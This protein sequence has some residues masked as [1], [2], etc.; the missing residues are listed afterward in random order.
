M[1]PPQLC[2]ITR[3]RPCPPV[4]V[5][6]EL[7]AQERLAARRQAHHDDC[8]PPIVHR[9]P[10]GDVRC[11]RERRERSAGRGALR[12]A[13][14]VL[15]PCTQNLLNP[16]RWWGDRAHTPIRRTAKRQQKRSI[17]RRCSP[18]PPA[19]DLDSRPTL[20]YARALLL[21]P[22][23]PRAPSMLLLPEGPE[24]N[25]AEGFDRRRPS[26][27]SA[28]KSPPSVDT[29]RRSLKLI[30]LRTSSCGRLRARARRW[31]QGVWRGGG[32]P[33]RLQWGRR[34]R[35]REAPAA[36]AAG[37][38]ST[39]EIWSSISGRQSRATAAA[40]RRR[41]RAR[42]QPKRR[43][44]P[45]AAAHAAR[46]CCCTRAPGP[47]SRLPR[48]TDRIAQ[49]TIDG[50]ARAVYNPQIEDSARRQPKSQRRSPL[51]RRWRLRASY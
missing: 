50:V 20:R 8:Q 47:R 14:Q 12:S 46:A 45:S 38:A 39:A 13:A 41:P 6:H 2:D 25:P 49:C 17:W 5:R 7:V 28:S 35:L 9:H 31:M 29:S 10:R 11:E 16:A 26:I 33:E 1:I 37:G 44:Q 22:L 23:C 36:A 42:Q 40:K 4:E 18:P 30:T 24:P 27:A 15:V 21:P 51:P 48:R 19:A 3:A 34:L 32:L 43:Q